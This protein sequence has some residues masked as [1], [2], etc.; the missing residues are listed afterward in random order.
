MDQETESVATLVQQHLDLEAEIV[1]TLEA[2]NEGMSSILRDA[3]IYGP[4]ADQLESLAPLLEQLQEQSDESKRSRRVLYGKVRRH[5]VSEDLET[6]GIETAGL[7]SGGLESL[8]L[9][10]LLPDAP[11]EVRARKDALAK[12]LTDAGQQLTANQVVLFYSME[13]HRRYLLGVLECDREESNYQ[14]DGQ[15]FKLPPEKI[16]GRNC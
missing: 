13:F 6:A 3:G 16:F 7:E 4:S 8:K 9:S 11:E 2:I 10:D 14:A 5:E 15:A 1:H 12:R